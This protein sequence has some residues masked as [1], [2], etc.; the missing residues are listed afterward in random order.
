M[1]LKS[2]IHLYLKE[3]KTDENES[4][5][6]Y[7]LP[8]LFIRTYVFEFGCLCGKKKKHSNKNIKCVK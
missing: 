3:K 5:N 8:L 2:V 4:N 7:K 6:N 1:Y